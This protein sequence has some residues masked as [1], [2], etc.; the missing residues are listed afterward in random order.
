MKRPRFLLL[1]A[2]VACVD[3]DGVTSSGP[4]AE[5]TDAR[6]LRDVVPIIERR[7]AIGGCHSVLTQ[8][9]GLVLVP[10][11]AFGAVVN[12]ASRLR[13]GEVLVRPG[14]AANSWLVIML[15]SDPARRR[16]LARMPLGSGALPDHQVRTIMN[17]INRGAPED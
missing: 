1:L 16:G 15:G 11:V 2:A 5:V 7:C 12:Q 13:E 17:W 4:G 10:D 8:Q 6:F 3:Y 9:A 14:D